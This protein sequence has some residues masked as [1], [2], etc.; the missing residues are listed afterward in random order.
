VLPGTT[1]SRVK[2]FFAQ[3]TG[4]TNALARAAEVRRLDLSD[5]ETLEWAGRILLGQARAIQHLAREIDDLKAQ[6]AELE[7]RQPRRRD[8]AS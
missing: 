7:A 8:V 4:E 2:G 6:L 1:E 5:P 3:T